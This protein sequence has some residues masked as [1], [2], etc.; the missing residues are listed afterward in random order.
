MSSPNGPGESSESHGAERI[1]LDEFF[2][3]ELAVET[4]LFL[5]MKTLA[6]LSDLKKEAPWIVQCAVL[7][8]MSELVS[9]QCHRHVTYRTQ[10]RRRC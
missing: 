3:T 5:H 8:A 7:H 1:D 4:A 6:E 9:V 10:R 2:C